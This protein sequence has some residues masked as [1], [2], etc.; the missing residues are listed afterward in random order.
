MIEDILAQI[1]RVSG[2]IG[3]LI[4]NEQGHL[5]A[6]AFPPIYDVPLLTSV[7]SVLTE[8][9]SGLDDMAGQVK[10]M[11]FR[12]QDG[13]VVIRILNGG[14]LA[15]LC[16]PA[17]NLQLLN[18]SLNVAMVRIGKLLLKSPDSLAGSVHP[19][20]PFHDRAVNLQ[21]LLQQGPLASPLQGMQATLAK[22]LGPMAKIIF[23]ECMEKWLEHNRPVKESLPQLIEIVRKEIDDP[24]KSAD[25]GQRVLT[26]L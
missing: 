14:Y 8:N 7:V 13:R 12:F 26:Y 21:A 25:Y 23:I 11:D 18:I 9:L 4:C 5:M 20:R 16:T 1:N 22:F 3:S 15:L 24:V 17:V 6:Y 19:D 2:T 10:M